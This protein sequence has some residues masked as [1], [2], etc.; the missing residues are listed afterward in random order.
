MIVCIT[1][2]QLRLATCALV[3]SIDKFCVT[4]ELECA[5]ENRTEQNVAG[6]LKVFFRQCT[7]KYFVKRIT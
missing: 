6:V 5:D 1:P 7:F 2:L 4:S 3:K